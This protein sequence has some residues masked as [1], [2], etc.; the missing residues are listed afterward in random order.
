MAGRVKG[1]RRRERVEWMEGEG[2]RGRG[3]VLCV[4][5]GP[6]NALTHPHEG[7]S[8]LAWTSIDLPWLLMVRWAVCWCV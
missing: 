7:S 6:L 8:P 5:G 1:D 4:V 2:G 3:V